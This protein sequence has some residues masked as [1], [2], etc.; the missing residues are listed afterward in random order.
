[1]SDIIEKKQF[2][3]KNDKWTVYLDGNEK[4]LKDISDSN[5][6]E[7][8]KIFKKKEKE[9]IYWGEEDKGIKNLIDQ[10]KKNEKYRWS[11]LYYRIITVY[12]NKIYNSIEKLKDDVIDVEQ[13][14]KQLIKHI[15]NDLN[16]IAYKTIIVDINCARKSGNL[17]GVTSEERLNFYCNNLLQNKEYVYNFFTYYKELNRI[18]AI[19]TQYLIGYFFEIYN[20]TI[21]YQG[22]IEKEIFNGNSLG[23]IFCVKFGMGDSHNYGRSVG[24]ITFEKGV[25]IIYKPRNL[26]IDLG[27][28]KLVNK[29]NQSCNQT[30]FKTPKVVLGDGFGW[31]EYIEG[32]RKT[33]S[34]NDVVEY[35]KNL[36]RMLCVLYTLNSSDLHSENIIAFGKWPIIVDLETIIQPIAS[37]KSTNGIEE[38]EK[39]LFNSV[40][41]TALLPLFVI[42]QHNGKKIEIGGMGNLEVQEAPFKSNAIVDVKKDTIHLE[43]IYNKVSE[44]KNFLLYRDKKVDAKNYSEEI[45]SGFREMYTWIEKNKYTY[46][47]WIQ[48]FFEKCSARVLFRSTWIYGNLLDL[49]YHP[50][51]MS[52][53]IDR[54]VF[55]HRVGLDKRDKSI[56]LKEID[57]MFNGDIPIFEI[58]TRKRWVYDNEYALSAMEEAVRR[59]QALDFKD[60]QLQLAI[61]RASL[62]SENKRIIKYTKVEDENVDYNYVIKLLVNRVINNS[63]VCSEKPDDKQWV[64]ASESENGIIDIRI[65][66]DSLYE[67]RAGIAFSFLCA[68]IATKKSEYK[69]LAKN[70]LDRIRLNSN[71]KIGAYDGSTGVLFVLCLYDKVTNE[72]RYVEKEREFLKY[73]YEN[74]QKYDDVEVL[75]GCA[76][77]YSFFKKLE[78]LLVQSDMKKYTLKILEHCSEMIR[79]HYKEV[80]TV[81]KE[82]AYLGYAHGEAGIL[83]QYAQLKNCSKILLNNEIDFQDKLYSEKNNNWPRKIGQNNFGGVGW[84]HGAP[85]IL[86]SREIMYRNGIKTEKLKN[87]IIRAWRSTLKKCMD[88]DYALCHGNAGNLMI[89]KYCSY[90]VDGAEEEID[91]LIKKF[92]NNFV[93][94][95]LKEEGIFDELDSNGLFCGLSGIIYFIA[96]I[97]NPQE[98]PMIL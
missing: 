20:H 18:L 72:Y 31:I 22:M 98:V 62:C 46:I 3:E 89:L 40:R 19:R 35:N 97:Q 49:S 75:S 66:D 38:V 85:G 96:W 55:L 28:E 92:I 1:M 77:I 2:I 71:E 95:N 83:S 47:K 88:K 21:D 54:Y 63:I 41:N 52:N 87:S 76:G 30:F 45:Q 33:N 16:E 10:I 5:F 93:Y 59:V 26:N 56:M 42:N 81:K 86:L 53:S 27:F 73:I 69:E 39:R 57:M 60:M 23:K 9:K 48:C 64:C 65:L 74:I 51:L 70:I 80:K 90:L 36:G 43:K 58:D 78:T 25:K 34:V 14:K 11:Y 61:I 6:E 82:N 24:V 12:R 44:N 13:V 68:Y 79:V 94:Q 15:I 67:G 84:C 29:I 8:F 50:D 17:K 4:T 91:K 7:M 32:N 37:D